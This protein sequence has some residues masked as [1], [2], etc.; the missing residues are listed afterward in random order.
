MMNGLPTLV[1]QTLCDKP[2]DQW[3]GRRHVLLW[4]TTCCSVGSNGMAWVPRA[5]HAF[6]SKHETDEILSS[7]TPPGVGTSL[8]DVAPVIGWSSQDSPPSSVVA[9]TPPRRPAPRNELH[10]AAQQSVA[11]GHDTDTNF[12]E[13]SWPPDA[14]D[15]S[16]PALTEVSARLGGLPFSP[17]GAEP[18]DPSAMA[19]QWRPAEHESA[20][21]GPRPDGTVDCVQLRPPL[22]VHMAIPEPDRLGVE[23]PTRAQFSGP[24]HASPLVE[25][26][27]G[28]D[29]SVAVQSAPPSAV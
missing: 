16:S 10:P 19:R 7:S 2:T 12:P 3:A 5:K 27:N 13:G 22:A 29:S 6:T 9:R 17:E 20:K 23:L 14:C 21:N 26:T 15:H 28:P 18:P 11:V 25:G 1:K 4:S 24:T 8:G